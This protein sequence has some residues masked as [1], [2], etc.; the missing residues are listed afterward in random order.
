MATILALELGCRPEGYDPAM[1]AS[2]RRLGARS[3][4]G[5]LVIRFL[6]VANS[7]ALLAIGALYLLYGARPA[8]LVVGGVLLGAALALLGCVPLTDPYRAPRRRG[9]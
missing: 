6:L 1:L 8:G 9:R 5:L 4:G 7:I 3:I 2:R